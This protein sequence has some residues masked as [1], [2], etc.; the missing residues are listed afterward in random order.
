MEKDAMI[1]FRLPTE[2]REALQKA[3]ASERRSVSNMAFVIIYDWLKSNGYL[4]QVA[5]TARRKKG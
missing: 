3:A 5:K 2:T 4:G 1:V